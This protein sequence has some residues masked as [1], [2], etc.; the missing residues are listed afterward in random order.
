MSGPA[1][2]CLATTV[3]LMRDGGQSKSNQ[4]KSIDLVSSRAHSIWARQTHSRPVTT[5][6]V[7]KV[8]LQGASPSCSHAPSCTSAVCKTMM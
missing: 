2:G 3:R 6:F 8:A 4:D 5:G 7:Y 1:T